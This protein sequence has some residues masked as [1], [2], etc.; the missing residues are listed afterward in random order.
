MCYEGFRDWEGL[1]EQHQ[2]IFVVA[3]CLSG[4]F[5]IL[6]L[7]AFMILDHLEVF[8]H[9]AVTR[10]IVPKGLEK[11]SRICDARRA[12]SEITTTCASSVDGP[13][14]RRPMQWAGYTIQ[15][16]RLLHARRKG[17]WDTLSSSIS[18][19]QHRERVLCVSVTK[20]V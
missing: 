13:Q 4:P 7:H 3:K 9:Q 17:L 8:L 20:K 11:I 16:H 14:R 10:R 19:S 15:A 2:Q 1:D 12:S 18:I 5:G 6:D